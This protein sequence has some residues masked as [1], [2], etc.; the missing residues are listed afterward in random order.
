ML[1]AATRARAALAVVPV[2]GAVPPEGVVGVV[3]VG[4]VGGGGVVVVGGG[5]AVLIG[6]PLRVRSH[7]CWRNSVSSSW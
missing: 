3:V 5:G 6:G 2:P 4:V 7:R 1:V